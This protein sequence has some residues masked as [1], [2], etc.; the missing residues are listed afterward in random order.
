MIF[1]LLCVILILNFVSATYSKFSSGQCVSFPANALRLVNPCVGVVTY[2]FYV[3]QGDSVYSMQTQANEALSSPIL[4]QYPDFAS[5]YI[6]Y[7]CTKIYLKCNPNINLQNS[8]TYNTEIYQHDLGVKYAIPF[9]RPCNSICTSMVASASSFLKMNWKI[10]STACQLK[11]DY[12]FGNFSGGLPYFF[13]QTNS[14]YC[15][16]TPLTK[17]GG[18]VEKYA[19]SFCKGLV[20]TFIVPPAN[21]LSNITA[22]FSVTQF[23]GVTQSLIELGFTRLK[24]KLIFIK[25]DCMEALK[26]YVCSQVLIQ[27]EE[28]TLQQALEYS[29]MQYLITYLENGSPGITTNTKLQ[30]PSYLDQF[31]CTDYSTICASFQRIAPKNIKANC[32]KVVSG[33]DVHV[34]PT[35]I[36]AVVTIQTA[37]GPLKFPTHPNSNAYFNATE[38]GYYAPDCPAGF[39][40]PEHPEDDNVQWIEGTGCANACK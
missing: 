15:Y 21:M 34:F 23:P 32:S 8:S 38:Y 17:I 27:P 7:V 16:T 37:A 40:A 12:S 28:V 5:H 3:A 1:H 13:D 14:S 30:L 19:G 39:V 24:K 31:Y 26:R 25:A 35:T 29:N 18:P 22:G 10:N 36:Q 20:N 11:Y 9:Q 2:P 6:Q 4:L 33:T